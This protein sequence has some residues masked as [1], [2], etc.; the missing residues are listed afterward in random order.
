[1]KGEKQAQSLR[2]SI[3]PILL[4]VGR[5]KKS[6]K[7]SGATLTNTRGFF[8]RHRI[9]DVKVFIETASRPVYIDDILVH[10]SLDFSRMLMKFALRF[11]KQTVNKN[12][13]F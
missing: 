5:I 2:L 1:M 8:L 12:I 3:V 13:Q 4:E 9:P 7:S 11:Y 10:L 6:D